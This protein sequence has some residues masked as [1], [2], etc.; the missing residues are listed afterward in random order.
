MSGSAETYDFIVTGAGSAGCVL[1]A[2][3]SESGRHRVLLLEAGGKDNHFWIHVP[4][5]YAKTFVDPR[6]NWMFD[7]E[8]EPNLNDRD[9]VPAARQGAGRHQFDQRHDLHA[10]QSRRLRPM[11]PAWLRRLGL[12]IGAAV[13]PQG[14][15]QRTRRRRIP[16]FRRA[17]ARVEPAVRM[18]DRQ[19]AAAGLH[20]GRHQAQSGLQRREPGRLRLLPDHDQGQAP[21]EHRRRLSAPGAQAAEPDH[22]HPCARHARAGGERPRGRRRIPHAARPAKR[23]APVARSSSPAAPTA[24]RSFCCCPASARRSICS[25]MGIDVVH[26]LPGVGS[27]LHDHFNTYCTWRI[28]NSIIAERAALLA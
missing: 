11:A 4:L 22:P 9:H 6:V 28:S 1:A 17:A 14:G 16:R 24:R 2:R 18:G 23:R 27:N 26:D 10:R 5:G 19:G 12:G 20:P 7:S 8:P 3:L 15:G 13:F 25:D 21:L